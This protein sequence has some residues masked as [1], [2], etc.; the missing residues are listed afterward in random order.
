MIGLKPLLPL[1]FNLLIKVSN[2]TNYN[3]ANVSHL[4]FICEVSAP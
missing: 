3:D 1:G 4:K 2:C